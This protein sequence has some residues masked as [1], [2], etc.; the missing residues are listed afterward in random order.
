M[1][2]VYI[3]LFLTKHFLTRNDFTNN[4]WKKFNIFSILL[5]LA[6]IYCSDAHILY[7][8]FFNKEK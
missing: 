6:E 5:L 7:Y 1:I 3:K 8:F 4:N 2:I